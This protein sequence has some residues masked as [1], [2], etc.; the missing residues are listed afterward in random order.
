MGLGKTVEVFA[1]ILKNGRDTKFSLDSGRPEL[2]YGDT[3]SNVFDS[4]GQELLCCFCGK[5]TKFDIKYCFG[6]RVPMHFRCAGTL[7]KNVLRY[8]CP[9]CGTKE[10]L[11]VHF[12]YLCVTSS[13]YCLF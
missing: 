8:F 7:G 10:V 6:C 1:L 2:D 5:Q 4:S 11:F 9:M 13:L 12:F 3:T